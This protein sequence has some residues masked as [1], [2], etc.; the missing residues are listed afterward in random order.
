MTNT[1][2]APATS[3]RPLDWPTLRQ[4]I[5]FMNVCAI[6]G[7][8]AVRAEG[9]T[10]DLPVSSGYKVRI[11]LAANDTYTVQRIMVRGGKVWVKG[12]MTDVYC[13]QIGEVAYVASCYK[14][15]DFGS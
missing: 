3:D 9:D 14:N 12:T 15:L 13:D 1:T 4:Q 6:S 11:A 7:G 8:R 10:I 2:T 5:G